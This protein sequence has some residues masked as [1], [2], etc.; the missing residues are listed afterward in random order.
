[1]FQVILEFPDIDSIKAKR[2]I[3]HSVRDKIQR[4][5]KMSV[6]EVDLL[7]SLTFSQLGGALVSNS[8]SHGEKVMNKVIDF[9]EDEVPGRVQ[10]V[11]IHTESY[12]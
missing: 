10:N 5:F 1:M 4:K 12:A 11:E 6:A 3:V 7:D 2:R 9:I 8:R